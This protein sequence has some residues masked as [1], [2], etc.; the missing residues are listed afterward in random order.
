[1]TDRVTITVDQGVADV[2][3]NR[4]DKLNALDHFMLLRVETAQVTDAD[5]GGD[6]WQP[7]AKPLAK[8]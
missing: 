1:M 4:P 6:E 5:D 8:S 2:R 7:R 3:L